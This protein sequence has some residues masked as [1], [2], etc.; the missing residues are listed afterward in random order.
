[1]VNDER[2]KRLGSSNVVMLVEYHMHSF[3]QLVVVFKMQHVEKTCNPCR[4]LR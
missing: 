3:V 4:W 1:M 2:N